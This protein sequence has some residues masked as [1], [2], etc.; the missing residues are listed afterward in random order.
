MQTINLA[1][2]KASFTIL[3][4]D[5]APLTPDYAFGLDA[6]RRAYWPIL[7]RWARAALI[8]Q[9][10][11]GLGAD[12]RPMTPALPIS[13][14]WYRDRGLQWRGPAMSPQYG[15]SRF[16]RHV[17]VVAFPPGRPDR[18]VGFWSHGTARIA[19]YHATGTAGRGR[20]YFDEGGRIRGWR[21]LPGQ[22]TGIVR[23]VVGLSPTS[24]AWAVG[25][26]RAEWSARH[27]QGPASLTLPIPAP[28][29]RVSRPAA[30]AAPMAPAP[31]PMT[32]A[33]LLERYP[34]MRQ[35]NPSDQP[36]LVEEP[37][38]LRRAARRLEPARRPNAFRR[39][40]RRLA[41]FLGGLFG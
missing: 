13:R 12:G 23:D 22:T 28:P 26:A 18:V 35:F 24:V 19:H 6:A 21:G 31:S 7:A 9:L 32:A 14:Q 38:A 36:A 41:G 11:A 20:P 34:F 29:R 25:Q 3:G 1:A 27:G 33:E 39:A 8:Q 5:V 16:Q 40:F 30:V 17:R 4:P 10:E 15:R 2:G 37:G